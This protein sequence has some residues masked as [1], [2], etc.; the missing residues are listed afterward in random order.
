MYCI[1]QFFSVYRQIFSEDV[2]LDAS[3]VTHC[4][5]KELIPTQN[6]RFKLTKELLTT[7][8]LASLIITSRI[9]CALPCLGLQTPVIFVD[10]EEISNIRSPNRFEGLI[11]LMRTM[12]LQNGKLIKDDYLSSVFNNEILNSIPTIENKYEYIK[13]KEKLLRKCKSFM[14]H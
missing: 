9:H 14:S 2:L 6:S 10:S 13:L 8:S 1:A 12:K 4:V 5:A 11:E 7:Y 3:Y